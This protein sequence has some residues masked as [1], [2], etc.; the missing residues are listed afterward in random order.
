MAMTMALPCHGGDEEQSQNSQKRENSPD[1]SRDTCC[2]LGK[3]E[4]PPFHFRVALFQD[5]LQSFFYTVFPL[6]HL[7]NWKLFSFSFFQEKLFKWDWVLCQSF[8]KIYL[9][10]LILLN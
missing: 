2:G 10:L 4:K 8:Q 6:K 1:D 9:F 7:F 3:V 5:S